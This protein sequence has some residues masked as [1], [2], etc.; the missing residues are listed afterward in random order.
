MCIRDSLAVTKEAQLNKKYKPLIDSAVDAGYEICGVATFAAPEVLAQRQLANA[1]ANGR[2][3]QN[4]PQC[5]DQN[6]LHNAAL[7]HHEAVDGLE[8][9][10][11][12]VKQHSGVMIVLDN[13]ADLTHKV[14]P[15]WVFD[16]GEVKQGPETMTEV[17][18]HLS[19]TV[20]GPAKQYQTGSDEQTRECAVCKETKPKDAFS[21]GQ[22]RKPDGARCVGCV[23]AAVYAPLVAKH[24]GWGVGATKR[25]DQ[26]QGTSNPK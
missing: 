18:E 26:V 3:V 7:K 12:L 19:S 15:F 14:G 17:K 8:A 25:P 2:L 16:S 20:Q 23:Q 24:K 13:T 9:L 11:A 5:T 4:H 6:L 22:W 21:K 1:T 10:H